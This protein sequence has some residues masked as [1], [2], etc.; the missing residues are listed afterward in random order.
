MQVSHKEE[1]VIKDACVLFDLIDLGLLD[2]FYCLN[3]V[4]YTTPQVINEVEDEKQLAMIKGYIDNNKLL[5]DYGG[6]FE[7]IQ[8]I[9]E[10]NRGLSFTDGSVIEL[11]ARRKAAVLSSDKSVRLISERRNMPVRGVLWIIE[12]LFIFNQIEKQHALSV[13][14]VYPTIN[15]RAP[16]KEIDLLIKRL[17]EEY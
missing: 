14:K 15:V 11:A 17:K 8:E 7:I 4:V 3:L 12:Q 2:P 10:E 9:M 6:E 13:L 5:V 16:R 1:I